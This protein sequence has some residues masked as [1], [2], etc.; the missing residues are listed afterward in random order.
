[1]IDCPTDAGTRQGRAPIG[2][3]DFLTTLGIR[4]LPMATRHGCALSYEPRSLPLLFLKRGNQFFKPRFG[5]ANFV[6]AVPAYQLL[7]AQT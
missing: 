6:R 7:A 2:Q 3:T 1:L 5:R 4:I